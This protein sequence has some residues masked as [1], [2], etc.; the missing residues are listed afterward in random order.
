SGA[1]RPPSRLD[2]DPLRAH[3]HRPR[4]AFLHRPTKRDT[5]LKLEGHTLGDELCVEIRAADIVDVDVRL[6]PGH[7]CE[8]LL[9]LLDL[10][11]LLADH[12]ARPRGVDVDL[13]L[14]RGSFDL[15]LGN[16]RMV[17]AL[18]D[19]AAQTYVLVKEARVVAF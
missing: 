15:D 3:A 16:S 12:D 6:L 19:E 11:T 7:A 10:R 2:A 9:E 17:E 4:Y 13:R 1:A 5:T 8:L 14:V 18:L